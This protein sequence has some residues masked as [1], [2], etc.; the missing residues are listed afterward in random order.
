M[1]QGACFSALQDYV[2]YGPEFIAKSTL[3]NEQI[4][5]LTSEDLL[6][7]IKDL[8]T[9]KHEV[10]YYGPSE[11]VAA[12]KM[13]MDHHKIADNPE[14]LVKERPI[15]RQ[16]SGNEVLLVPYDA[17]QFYYVQYSDRG[18]KFDVSNDPGVTMYNNYFGSGMNAI[19]FQ[20]MREARGLAYSARASLNTPSYPEDDYMFYAFIASQNDKLKDAVVEFDRIINQ[21]PESE[22]AFQVA[23]ASILSQLR[24]KRVTGMGVLNQ[25]LSLRDLGLSE[26]RDKAVFEAVQ[27]MTLA[28]VKAFQEKWIKN[29]EYIYGFLGRESDFDTEFIS[30]LGP[31]KHLTLEDVFGY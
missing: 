13:V 6:G 29:R 5:S 2:F 20:E 4:L 12:R 26:S 31:V 17:N 19:V 27:N 23:K 3:S 11:E 1:S 28:D 10:L 30:T 22:K 21:M 25:Y 14:P 15:H 9:K 18:E 7:A 24:T 8:F 16:V